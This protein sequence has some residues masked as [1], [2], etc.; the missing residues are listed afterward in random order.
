MGNEQRRGRLLAMLFVSLL[1]TVVSACW[2]EA[3]VCTQ[4]SDC[5][6]DETCVSSECRLDIALTPDVHLEDDKGGGDG[7]SDMRDEQAQD[8]Q[9]DIVSE[10]DH[11]P[12]MDS[13]VGLD[14]LGARDFLAVEQLERSDYVDD[15]CVL[16]LDAHGSPHLLYQR[17]EGGLRGR[18]TADATPYVREYVDDRTSAC[19]HRLR[20]GLLRYGPSSRRCVGLWY[21]LHSR[22]GMGVAT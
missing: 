2:R 3:R 1:M 20:D 19:T 13:P 10:M 9:G 7:S 14:V 4:D 21:G 5:F 17:G 11:P 8:T 22:E 6:G 12:E 15:G 16:A 18:D